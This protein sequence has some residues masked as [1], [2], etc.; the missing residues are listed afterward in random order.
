MDSGERNP[1]LNNFPF[2]VDGSDEENQ[3]TKTKSSRTGKW[4]KGNIFLLLKTNTQKEN[5]KSYTTQNR[6]LDGKI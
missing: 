5:T 2:H 6:K 1:K 3:I 4:R